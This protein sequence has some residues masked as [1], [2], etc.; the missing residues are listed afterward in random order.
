MSMPLAVVDIVDD[1]VE[2]LRSVGRV[3]SAHGYPVCMFTS[4]ELYLRT[5]EEGKACCVVVSLGL[6]GSISGLDVGR[7][8]RA[9]GRAMPVIFI[10]GSADASMKEEALLTGCLAYLEEPVSSELLIS[11][12][13]RSGATSSWH[14]PPGPGR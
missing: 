8:V 13:R 11:A 9:S 12:V 7:A 5:V 2:V 6:R 14:P 1:N 4:A 10:A 3:L